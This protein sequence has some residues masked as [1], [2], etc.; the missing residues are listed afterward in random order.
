MYRYA[1]VISIAIWR[2]FRYF[3]GTQS[4]WVAW[5]DMYL[6]VWVK[7]GVPIVRDFPT[8]WPKSLIRLHCYSVPLYSIFFHHFFRDSRYSDCRPTGENRTSI[9]CTVCP[10]APFQMT[11]APYLSLNSCT[12]GNVLYVWSHVS[13]KFQT[14]R[15]L[16]CLWMEPTSIVFRAPKTRHILR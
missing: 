3:A 12:G 6:P 9:P 5:Q 14:V 2:I 11:S 4:T 1:E 13:D 7:N 8:R 15:L 10:Q 16:F